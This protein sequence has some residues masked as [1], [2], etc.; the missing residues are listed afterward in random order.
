MSENTVKRLNIDSLSEEQAI[1]LLR[2]VGIT[3][4]MKPV[5]IVSSGFSS[6]G[7]E[8]EEIDIYEALR[9]LESKRF[10]NDYNY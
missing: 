6:N 7:I 5:A 8:N 10:F 4:K 1:N 9:R 2:E 3:V